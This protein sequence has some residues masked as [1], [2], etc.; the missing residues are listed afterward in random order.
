M[1]SPRVERLIAESPF[2]RGFGSVGPDQK[3]R[4]GDWFFIASMNGWAPVPPRAVGQLVD[5]REVIRRR[6]IKPLFLPLRRKY[7]DWF[8]SGVKTF[9]FRQLGGRWT[10]FNC[11]PGRE[12]ILSLGYGRHRRLLGKIV[13]CQV[14][15]SDARFELPGYKDCY[16]PEAGPAL[17]IFIKLS[18]T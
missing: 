10:L 1:N 6:P 7:F 12:V 8:A 11:Y 14:E 16:G 2:F 9:E 3:V 5:S 17:C 4:R 13:G 18:T 15:N